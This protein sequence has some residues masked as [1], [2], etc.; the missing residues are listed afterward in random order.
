MSFHRL[1]VSFL[2]RQGQQSLENTDPLNACRPTLGWFPGTLRPWVE[3]LG[4]S[5]VSLLQKHQILHITQ[6]HS[7][8]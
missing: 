5:Q 2:C 7:R 8:G 1:R 4:A 3:S 6:G